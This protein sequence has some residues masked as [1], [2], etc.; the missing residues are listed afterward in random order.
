MLKRVLSTIIILTLIISGIIL[1]DIYLKKTTNEIIALTKTAESEVIGGD[2]VSAKKNIEVLQQKWKKS[3]N[4]L[5]IFIKHSD[6][7]TVN[8]SVSKLKVYVKD[9]DKTDFFAECDTIEF[10]LNTLA[11]SESY[12]Y[13]NIL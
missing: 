13:Y 2:I 5:A 11:D 8:A 1:T 12:A 7:D 3:R 6:I 10:Y 9:E 4:V